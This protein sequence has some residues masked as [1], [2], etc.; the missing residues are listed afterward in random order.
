MKLWRWLRGGTWYYCRPYDNLY[1]FTYM[2]YWINRK[3]LKNEVV[4]KR[5]CY[6]SRFKQQE[7]RTFCY[8]PKCKNELCGTDSFVRDAD[9]VYYKCSCCGE[10]SKWDFDTWMVPMVV[11][12]KGEP[13]KENFNIEV[14]PC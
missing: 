12:D 8:C 2:R 14:I 3:P 10:E 6:K 11:D 7:Q 5:E 1:S 4:L 13:L 9:Y